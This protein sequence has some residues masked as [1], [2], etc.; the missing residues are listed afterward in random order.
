MS[1]ELTLKSVLAKIKC[2][3][4]PVPILLPRPP[5]PFFLYFLSHEE[6][7]PRKKAKYL[8]RVRT[9]SYSSATSGIFPICL[10][11]W[12][13]AYHFSFQCYLSQFSYKSSAI[14]KNVLAK[15]AK[16][17][18]W[19]STISYS[20]A[21]SAIFPVCLVLWVKASWQKN[22]ISPP[23]QNHFSLWKINTFYLIVKG[24]KMHI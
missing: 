17:L 20:I 3:P 11:P 23:S 6:E 15:K 4:E 21:T 7:H 13:R 2:S 22:K 8:P 16:A 18:P 12:G 24:L 5:V 14:R 19:A 9:I 1:Q 10:E